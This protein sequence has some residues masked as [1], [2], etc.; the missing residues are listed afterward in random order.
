VRRTVTAARSPEGRLVAYTDI[1][2]SASVAWHAN[3]GDTIV[4][5]AHRG[6]RLGMLVKLANLERVR[7]DSPE[8][9]AIDTYNA[10]S[11][12]WMVSINEAMGYRP[13]DRLGEWEI[14]L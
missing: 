2:Q 9:R 5:P 12:P 11:N 6:R 4:E 10:D 1:F 3:Q 8:L 7:R 14:D 13:Y